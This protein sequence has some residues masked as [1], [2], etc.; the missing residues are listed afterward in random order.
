MSSSYEALEAGRSKLGRTKLDSRRNLQA[1]FLIW[2]WLEVFAIPS[3]YREAVRSKWEGQNWIVHVE[4]A[5]F[6]VEWI[7]FLFYFYLSIEMN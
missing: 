3:E 1:S 7:N 5:I 4:L 6:W 2:Y